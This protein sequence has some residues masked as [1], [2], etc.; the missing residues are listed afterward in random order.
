MWNL[1]NAKAFDDKQPTK[2][3]LYDKINEKIVNTYDL[4]QRVSA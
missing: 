2:V 1:T 3:Q 4:Q